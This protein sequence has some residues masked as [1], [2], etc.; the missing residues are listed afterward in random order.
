M[1]RSILHS[2]DVHLDLGGR[3]TEFHAAGSQQHLA[4]ADDPERDAGV[5]AAGG[6]I[7]ADERREPLCPRPEIQPH[8]AVRVRAQAA[9]ELLAANRQRLAGN[10]LVGLRLA[11]AL[12]DGRQVQRGEP[13]RLGGSSSS[14]GQ[15]NS[16]SQGR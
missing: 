16:K 3:L 14:M 8:K 11:P 1:S 4:I 12:D 13:D 2:F 5:V 9:L 10:G 15:E 7:H 6:V